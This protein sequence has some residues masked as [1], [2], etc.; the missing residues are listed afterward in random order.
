VSA[1]FALFHLQGRIRSTLADLHTLPDNKN[2]TKT[3]RFQFCDN[4]TN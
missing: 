3:G 2:V 4:V 1:A